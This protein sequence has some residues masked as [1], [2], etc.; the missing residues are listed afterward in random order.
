[1]AIELRSPDE[2]SCVLIPQRGVPLLLPNESVAEI[3]RGGEVQPREEVP[4]WLLGTLVWRGLTIPVVNVAAVTTDAD[5]DPGRHE[6]GPLVVLNRSRALPTLPFYAM[7]TRGVP[8]LV[9]L[10]E[11][12]LNLLVLE[13]PDSDAAALGLSVR[14]G[15]EEAF[16]PRL[17][18][19]EDL[20]LSYLPH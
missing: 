5:V 16:I 11:E 17:E 1:M 15:S 9:R 19:V 10:L 13:D 7:P 18:A 12:D 6:G 8:R 4:P 20:L 3:L 14:L 2:L